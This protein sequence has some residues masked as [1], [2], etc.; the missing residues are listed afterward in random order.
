[1]IFTKS[2]PL[3]ASLVVGAV[4][5][6]LPTALGVGD[7]TLLYQND[8]DRAYPAM[9]AYDRRAN[10]HVVSTAASHLTALLLTSR[11]NFNAASACSSLHE[12]L[13]SDSATG[14]S[15]DLVDLLKYQVYL[16]HYK[17]GQQ[18][19]I[20]SKGG[21][22]RTVDTNGVVRPA[23]CILESFPVLCSQSSGFNAAPSSTNQVTVSSGR[24]SITG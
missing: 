12:T 11:S 23:L 19:W 10:F 4:G 20:S 5:T 22:C 21:E 3:L 14:F 2:F 7:I 18:F 24:L 13:L 9:L 16:G 8:L 6:L 1:M 15:T 17:A